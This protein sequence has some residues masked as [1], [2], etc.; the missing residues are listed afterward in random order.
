MRVCDRVG[1]DEWWFALDLFTPKLAVAGH[2][3]SSEP[4]HS[5]PSAKTS[6]PPHA[7]SFCDF[8]LF[9]FLDN[10]AADVSDTQEQV[11]L[12]SPL[13]FSTRK[14][15]TLFLSLRDVSSMMHKEFCNS[16]ADLFGGLQDDTTIHNHFFSDLVYITTILYTI[17]WVCK[18]TDR[19]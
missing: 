15:N 4:V 10:T 1:C 14:F 12:T 16:D 13:K 8:C 17:I 3:W 9:S 11:T 7:V 2:E 5:A 6:T 19:L 18:L